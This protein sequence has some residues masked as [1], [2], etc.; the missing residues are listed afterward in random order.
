MARK[1]DK[2]ETALQEIREAVK[3]HGEAVGLKLM[4]ERYSDVPRSTWKRWMDQLCLSPAEVAIREAKKAADHMPAAPSPQYLAE[5]PVEARRNL[6][7][8]A[9]LE[10]LY[11]EAEMLRDYSTGTATDAAGNTF[12]KI[13]IPTYF[14]Q[15]IKLRSDLLEGAVRTIQQVYDLQRMQRFYDVILEEIAAE[16]PEVAQRITERLARLD[17]E[18]GMTVNARV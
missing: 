2:K 3:T 1:S 11:Q 8:M 6:D 12:K 15:S 14:A 10:E 13:K 7:F 17:A 18:I 16:S 9:R 5:R 4:R